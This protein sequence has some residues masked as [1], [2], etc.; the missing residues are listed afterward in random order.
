MRINVY[1]DGFNLYY[2]CVKGTP[3]KWLNPHTLCQ[4]VFPND[5]INRIRYFTAIVHAV[6]GDPQKPQR[7]LTYIRALQTIRG[8]SVHYGLFLS[9]VERK[10]LSKPVAGGPLLV[11]VVETQ[12]KGSDVNL[13]TYLLVDGYEEDYEAAIVVS[14]DS[15]L[16]EPISV[17]RNRL[18]RPVGVLNPQMD[19]RKTSWALVNAAS[20]YRRIRTGALAASQFS[21]VLHDASG[22][23][24]K[25]AGW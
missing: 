23:I 20:F 21:P 22:D 14:N 5:Q 7:Q 11:D 2:G 1:I 17:V 13:A 3:Y 10:P 19:R 12:E 24:Q 15:D 8:L 16:V 9:H 25:P 6:P 4:A 18:H